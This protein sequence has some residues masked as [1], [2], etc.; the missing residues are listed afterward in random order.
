MW[1]MD[2]GI[3]NDRLKVVDD[4]GTALKSAKSLRCHF[5]RGPSAF[6]PSLHAPVLFIAESGC[7][8]A[9]LISFNPS[10]SGSVAIKR[11][12]PLRGFLS[13]RFAQDA[14]LARSQGQWALSHISRVREARSREVIGAR[15][16]NGRA[17]YLHRGDS[18]VFCACHT[19]FVSLV[20]LLTATIARD[21][22]AFARSLPEALC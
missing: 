14:A 22:C 10:G 15:L 13:I 20:Y 9:Y 3:V 7:V 5:P 16:S 21:T 12:A 11:P 18:A 17:Q 8:R 19:R 4:P 6:T 2:A 1:L